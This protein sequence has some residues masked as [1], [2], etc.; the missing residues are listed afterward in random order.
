MANKDPERTAAT[1]RR[2][3][4]AYWDIYAAD[5]ARAVT[6]S[7]VVEA[8]GVRRSTFYQYFPD[9]PAV[10]TAIEDELAEMFGTEASRALESGGKDPAGIVQRVYVAHGDRLSVLL[11]ES[12]DPAFA[13]RI[14]D[15]LAPVAARGL[16]SAENA[17]APYLFEFVVTGILA[18]VT[19]WYE[20]GRDLDPAEFGKGIRGVLEAVARV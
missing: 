12:G 6:V 14:K 9:A 11:G 20:R 1:R 19:L 8:A 5:P 17:F 2:I 16:G 10:L 18:A 3:M 13:R 4:D 7:A 15:A